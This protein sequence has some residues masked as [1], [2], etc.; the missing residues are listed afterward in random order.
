M[1]RLVS[2]TLDII[3]KANN[4]PTGDEIVRLREEQERKIFDDAPKYL[5]SKQRRKYK[6]ILLELN[7]VKGGE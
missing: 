2:A 6:K 3:A 7:A 5:N 1:G 4:K